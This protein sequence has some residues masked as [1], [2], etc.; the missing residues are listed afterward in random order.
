M[1]PAS[2]ICVTRL[3]TLSN[4][5]WRSTLFEITL[6]CKASFLLVIN[7]CCR[8]LARTQ[9]LLFLL[10]CQFMFFFRFFRFQGMPC[11]QCRYVSFLIKSTKRELSNSTS[12]C[13]PMRIKILS[14]FNYPM[15]FHNFHFHLNSANW[16]CE[17][18]SGQKKNH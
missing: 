5:R 3:K 18:T 9:R 16:I 7:G 13:S 11:V 4:E 12:D 17:R 14:R 2:I 10:L 1:C 6:D 8:S 15:D